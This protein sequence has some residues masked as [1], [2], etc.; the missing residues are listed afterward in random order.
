MGT[1]QVKGY[2]F[3]V[4]CIYIIPI[5]LSFQGSLHDLNVQHLLQY[6]EQFIDIY[7]SCRVLSI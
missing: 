3:T 1:L 4:K 5:L 7:I 6:Y 2:D